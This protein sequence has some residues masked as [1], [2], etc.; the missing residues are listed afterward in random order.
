MNTVRLID[1]IYLY[2]IWAVH[3]IEHSIY[4]EMIHKHLFSV[5][6]L[7]AETFD[8]KLTLSGK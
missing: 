8:G 1:C 6:I 3:E 2:N 5:T 7:E 4:G